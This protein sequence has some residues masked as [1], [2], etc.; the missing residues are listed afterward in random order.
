MKVHIRVSR[1]DQELVSIEYPIETDGTPAKADI[2]VEAVCAAAQ[3]CKANSLVSD[4]L[5]DDDTVIEFS[6]T[7]QKRT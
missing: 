1:H 2:W 3:A 5:L 6:I 4:M 7:R